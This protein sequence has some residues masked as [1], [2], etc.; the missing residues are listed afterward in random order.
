[1]AL[2]PQYMQ[3]GFDDGQQTLTGYTDEWGQKWRQNSSGAWEKQTGSDFETGQA[4][5]SGDDPNRVAPDYSAY[6]SYL[7]RVLPDTT[8]YGNQDF[9]SGPAPD[10][11]KNPWA[12]DQL[13]NTG[14]S[15]RGSNINPYA[16]IQNRDALRSAAQKLGLSAADADRAA[17]DYAQT[18]Y[19][20]QGETYSEASSPGIIA[21][22]IAKRL[23]AQ[24]GKSYQGLTPD[25]Q[26]EMVQKATN[27]QNEAKK[28]DQ[29]DWK[30]DT[31]GGMAGVWMEQIQNAWEM[32]SNNG[33]PSEQALEGG[34]NP[35]NTWLANKLWNKD[36]DPLGNEYGLPTKDNYKQANSQGY[37]TGG[38]EIIQNVA[39]QAAG[40]ML[41]GAGGLG[42]VA[43]EFGASAEAIQAAQAA[44][45]AADAYKQYQNYQNGG[46]IDPL[47]VAGT[48]SA[49]AGSTNFSGGGGAGGDLSGSPDA[50]TLTG[51]APDAGTT[52][53]SMW[54]EAGNWV[55]DPESDFWNSQ[56][57][58]NSNTGSG[59][60]EFGN[61]IEG[62]T[63]PIV[64]ADGNVIGGGGVWDSIKSALSGA[65]GSLQNL[66]KGL[67][68]GGANGTAASG[69]ARLLGIG[70]STALG[71]AGSKNLSNKY[72]AMA[73][74]YEGFGQ[75]YRD[76]L[77]ATY[78]DPNAWLNSA[79]VQAPVQQGTNA[80]ARSLSMKGNPAG[81]PE[82]MGEIQ[83]YA[84]NQLFGKL[85]QE[86]DRLAGFGGLST[87]SAAAPGAASK[88]ADAGAGVYNA[89]GSGLADLTNPQPSLMD[90]LKQLKAQGLA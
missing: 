68:G 1:M 62:D 16:T 25:Q 5:W 45:A 34:D 80:L 49:V 29:E 89:A 28:G 42:A 13:F 54:D 64:D 48:A 21:N 52:G 78:K 30:K 44:K 7:S 81:S 77:A 65:G 84:S 60:D 86:R 71:A 15:G 79:E 83:N 12:I 14:Y 46:D 9:Y 39:Q 55:D 56:G 51:A 57:A 47:A 2:S 76:R 4:I 50:G 88:A 73:K 87:F 31:F 35:W 40:A 74:R 26:K 3:S 61:P 11:S 18:H 67:S 90:F 20:Q 75:D 22:E 23:F 36:Y 37:D 82:A 17:L 24:A 8:G 59:F 43:G 38:A 6:K 69:L 10:Q 41:A 53:G 72:D 19:N 66:L 58:N 33:L 32:D 63:G 85:G 27:Y 70:G